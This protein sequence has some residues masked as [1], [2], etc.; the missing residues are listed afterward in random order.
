ML[1]LVAYHET[2]S[3]VIEVSDD[4]GGISRQRVRAR[5]VERGI[6][7]PDA[8]LSDHE[9]LML[10][11][12]PGFSTAEAVTQLSGRGVGMDV[13]KKNIEALRGEIELSSVEGRGT[14]IRLRMPLTLAIIDGFLVG[15]GE[16][17]FVI[18]LDMV[19]ECADHAPSDSSSVRGTSIVNFRGQPLPL[20]RLRDH[21]A[22]PGTSGTGGRENIVVV[23]YA[24]RRAGILVE[25]LHGEFQ[26]VIKPLSKLFSKVPGVGGSTILGSG[27][28]AL[29]LDVP[30][31][32][33]RIER[34]ETNLAAF[35]RP[36]FRTAA[37]AREV[38]HA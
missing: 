23:E 13:V 36:S 14:T 9:L 16:R 3:I 12:E 21:F 18:P 22:L 4:G 8:E 19:V 15:V 27:E 32:V 28:I 11:F 37:D 6:I 34:N 20:V 33:Q 5:A 17:S 38:A 30:A 26:T 2:G 31:L 1:R 24:G 25:K 29:I 7:G 10:I 35:Q